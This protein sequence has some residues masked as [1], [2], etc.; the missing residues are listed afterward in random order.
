MPGRPQNKGIDMLLLRKIFAQGEMTVVEI[1]EMFSPLSGAKIARLRRQMGLK[2][3]KTMRCI[4]CN[5]M[6]ALN[7]FRSAYPGLCI[8]C[9]IAQGIEESHWKGNKRKVVEPVQT[10]RVKCLKCEP[11]RWFLSPVGYDGKAVFHICPTHRKTNGYLGDQEEEFIL[12]F[13]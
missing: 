1:S 11:A 8:R 9:R 13:G 3:P 12:R 7:C 4:K 6:K 10:V 2:T 5:E